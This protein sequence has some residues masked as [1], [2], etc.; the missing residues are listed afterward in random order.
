M[1]MLIFRFSKN[2]KGDKKKIE[3]INQLM[4]NY[5]DLP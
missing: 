3:D 4:G 5:N 2:E 1:K